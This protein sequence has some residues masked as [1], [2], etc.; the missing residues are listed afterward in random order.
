MRSNRSAERQPGF[1][2]GAATRISATLPCAAEVWLLRTA[3][4]DLGSLD[5]LALDAGERRRAAALAPLE[6]GPGYI[7]GHL[8]LRQLLGARLGLEPHQL[9][10]RRERCPSCGG[11][12]GRPALRH[13]DSPLQFSIS[14]SRGVVLIGL[15]RTPIGVDIEAIPGGDIPRDVGSLLHPGE[16]S[17]LEAAPPSER[18]ALFVRIWTRKEAFLK[19]TGVGVVTHLSEEYL[20]PAGSSEGPAAW[21]VLELAVGVDHAAAVALPAARAGA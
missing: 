17:D 1:P 20:G 2:L 5:V 12:H 19:A 11:P 7:A 4:V 3:E 18:G 10:Y 13:P 14:R 16:R 15:A 6:Q 21:T 9:S 8:L